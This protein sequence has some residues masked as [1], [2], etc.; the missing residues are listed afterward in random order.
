MSVKAKHLRAQIA[1]HGL[2][3]T[4]SALQ[5]ALSKKH[6]RPDEFSLTDL[7]CHLLEAGGQPIGWDGVRDIA[8]RPDQWRLLESAG[9]VSS[10]AFRAITHRIVSAAVL[11]GAS[12][13][14]TP[15]RSRLRV[16]TGRVR[17]GEFPAPTMPLAQGRTIGDIGEAE[18][19]PIMP[20]YGYRMRSLPARKKGAQIPITREAIVADDT[21]SVLEAARR[22]GEAIMQTCEDLCADLVGGYIANCVI[23]RLPGASSDTTS[24]LYLSSGAWTNEQVNALADWTDLDDAEALL[25]G[26]V[27]PNTD[28]PPVLTRRTLIVPTMLGTLAFRIL[29]AIETRSGT[30]SVVVAP[31]PQSVQQVELIVSPHLYHRAVAAGASTAQARGRW[32]YGDLDQAFAYYE[33]WPLEVAEDA[34]PDSRWTHDIWMRFTASEYGIPVVLQPRII[35]RN[36]PA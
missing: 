19:Y 15:L 34:T 31:N 26:N 32:Y 25:Q 28:R 6:I 7:A 18:E 35:S 36:L 3:A 27:L 8:R 24:N 23:E 30:S 10:A 17:E 2:D 9:S 33:I 5:E 20:V 11:E 16:V 29:N 13:P 12:V 1:A 21:G 14:A 4:A 22:V